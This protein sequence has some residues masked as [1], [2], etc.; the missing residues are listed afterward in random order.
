MQKIGMVVRDDNGGLGNL[1]LEAWRHLRPDVTLV[2]QSRPCRG[3]PHPAI[4]EEAWTKVVYAGNPVESATWQTLSEMADV[5]WSAETWYNDLAE[6]I[7]K[8]AG[9]KSILYAM[10]ELFAGSQADEVWNPTPYLSERSRL[11]D[12]V[13][14]PTSPPSS[15]NVRTKVRRI[16]HI[17]GGAQYDRNGTQIFLDALRH[18]TNPCAVTLHQP[19]EKY[20]V[21]PIVFSDLPSHITIKQSCEYERSLS[22]LYKWCDLVVLPRKYAGLCLPAYEAFGHGALVMMPDVDPQ[23]H[24]PIVGFEAKR[25]RP[26]L[27]KGGKIPM[28]DINPRTLAARIDHL[29]E[30]EVHP[31]VRASERGRAW[32]KLNSWENRKGEW[33]WRL[34][35]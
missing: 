11:G 20:R 5:W 3:E 27:M 6:S 33:L 30:A 1:T 32:A 28:W 16:L 14:W 19:D 26:R 10:P 8:S 23:V 13:P 34:Q 31:V 21:N 29:L 4:F 24:W 15:W 22:S 2:V 18:V 9:C 7:L 35:N 12:V 25:S 17:S